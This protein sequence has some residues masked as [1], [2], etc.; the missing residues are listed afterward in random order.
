M[1]RPLIIA[2]ALLAAATLALTFAQEALAQNKCDASTL[3]TTLHDKM[4][5]EGM[6]DAAIRGVLDSNIKRRALRGRVADSS[7]CT[8]DQVDAALKQLA[9]ATKG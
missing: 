7:G 6:N 4:K 1:Q 5:G 9:T 3:S 2:A 8:P